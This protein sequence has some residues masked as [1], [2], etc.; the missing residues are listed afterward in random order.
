MGLGECGADGA[1][2]NAMVKRDTNGSPIMMLLGP[3]LCEFSTHY[4]PD[5]FILMLASTPTMSQRS[6]HALCSITSTLEFSVTSTLALK[7]KPDLNFLQFLSQ[8]IV[9]ALL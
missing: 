7:P 5:L 4:L 9:L 1:E 6:Y 3:V 2:V 8:L